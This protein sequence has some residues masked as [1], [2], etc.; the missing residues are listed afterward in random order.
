MIMS[1]D[2]EKE[3]LSILKMKKI[4]MVLL[5]TSAYFAAEVVGGVVSGSLA[6]IADAGHMLTDVGALALSLFAISYARRP[7]TPQRTY[8][9]YRME[10][11]ASLANS[12]VLLLLSGYILYEAYQRIMEPPEIQSPLMIAVAAAGLGVNF[13]GMR[14]LGEDR[15]SHGSHDHPGKGMHHEGNK[16]E[17]LNIE[18]ARLEVFSDTLGSIGVIAA[19]IVVLTTKFYLADPI[20]SIGLALF[21]LPRTWSLIKKS[22]HIL[23]EGV[24]TNISYEAVKNAILNIRGVTGVFELHI[25]SITSGMNALS[26]HVAVIDPGRSQ[27]ILKEITAILENRFG[28][29]HSTIQIESYHPESSST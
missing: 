13:G 3:Q 24:P 20:V 21:I 12:L 6:L 29:D 9:F 7:P 27:A 1:R 22:I 16:E 19:G 17:N 28:I 2:N 26:A 4:K 25:W 8:G 11:L 23:M 5:L 15:H 14:L 18:A 10:I